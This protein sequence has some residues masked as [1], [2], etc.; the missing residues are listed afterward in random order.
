MKPLLSIVIPTKDRYEYLLEL[1]LFFIRVERDDFEVIV[2]DN[3]KDNIKI[4]EFLEKH[5]QKRIKY[6]YNGEHL[7]VVENADLAVA[8]AIGE[9]V[10]MI[11]DDDGISMK[12]ID[13]LKKMNSKYDA[14]LFNK[15]TY[16]WPDVTHRYH[17]SNFSGTITIKEFNGQIADLNV[18]EIIANVLKVGGTRILN[19]PRVY[20]AVI[21]RSVMDSLRQTA[22]TYFPGPSPDMANAIAISNF[23]KKMAYVDIPYIISGTSVKSTAG[24]GA[25]G[26]HIGEIKDQAFL[27]KETSALWSKNIPYYWSGTTIYAASTIRALESLNKIILLKKM[28]LSF[29]Y[30]SCLVFDKGMRKRILNT[31][32]GKFGFSRIDC[33][34][35]LIYYLF[36]IYILRVKIYVRNKVLSKGKRNN[37]YQNLTEIMSIGY[38]INTIDSLISEYETGSK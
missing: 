33:Y 25:I 32:W 3:S 16:I 7:S 27:P 37:N 9:Y 26:K 23:V 21:K 6:F 28:N 2:Q 13:F 24:A 1:L 20:H 34:I 8:N 31:I 38:A 4:V 11:G 10:T 36:E 22:G 35:K 14:Y 5:N 19:L 18:D 30:A 17:S 15:P 29:L 12:L